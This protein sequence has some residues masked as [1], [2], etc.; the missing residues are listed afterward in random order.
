[1]DELSQR[2]VSQQAI[3]EETLL[4]ALADATRQCLLKLLMVEELNVTE[5]VDILALPQST[6]SRHLRTLRE[7]GLVHDR[8]EGTS[9]LYS[10]ATHTV[11]AEQGAAEQ[12]EAE[13]DLGAVL[14]AWLARRPLP[15]VMRE[16]LERVIRHREMSGSGFF[17]RLGKRWDDLRESAFGTTF[18][19]EALLSLLPRHGTVLDIG[20]GTGDILPVLA[21]NF[22]RVI[23][24]EPAKNMLACARQRV[25]E[26]GLSNVSFCQGALASL[27]VA[28]KTV[29]LAVAILVVHHVQD[30]GQA[31]AEMRRVVRPGGR[32]LIVEQEAHENQA[33][34][35]TMRDLWWGFSPEELARD[36]SAAGFGEIRH[37]RMVTTVAAQGAADSPPLFVLT[38]ERVV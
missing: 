34:Y 16:R 21:G 30:R 9:T 36:L 11:A 22:E 23:A 3:V 15:P 14:S 4:R 6:V 8:R 1:M 28:A 27:P 17:D 2:S 32:V 25:G 7:A 5:L 10:A 29:D 24:V 26:Y 31:L 38:G 19:T 18:A 12:G 33:F 37:R 35:E 13:E 20:T